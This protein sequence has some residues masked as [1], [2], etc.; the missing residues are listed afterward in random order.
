M[1]KD[2][3][4]GII[5][6]SDSDLEV[7]SEAAKILEEFGVF[8]EMTVASA[9]RS[10]ELAR[11]YVTN[12][13]NRGIKIIIAGAG[14]AAH[15]AGVAASLTTLPIIGVPTKAKTLDGLDSLLSTVGMPPGVPVATVGI[16]AAKNAGILALQILA[17][18]DKSLE[19]KMIIYK[20]KLE[21]DNKIKGEKLLKIGFKKYLENK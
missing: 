2:I 18:S 7:M 10:S 4:V 11:K 20:K 13:K 9:H 5:M 19:N 12:A 8:Y 15:L 3:K 1:K 17:I 14:G 6:G 16:N 21:E